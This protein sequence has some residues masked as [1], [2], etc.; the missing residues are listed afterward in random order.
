MLP[1]I[2]S[3]SCSCLKTPESLPV[4]S[5]FRKMHPY[6]PF[7]KEKKILRHKIKKLPGFLPGKSKKQ[8]TRFVLNVI[9]HSFRN[10]STQFVRFFR[11]NSLTFSQ[12]VVL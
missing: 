7:R 9:Y 5:F 3:K 8:T 2:L 12:T 1:I 4:E 10:L 6:P 11:T